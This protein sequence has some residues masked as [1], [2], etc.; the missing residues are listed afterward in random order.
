MEFI[1]KK[2]EQI[3]KMNKEQFLEELE[4]NLSGLP[5]DEIEEIMEDYREHFNI[6]KKKKRREAEIA[7]SLGN[8]KEIALEAKEELKSSRD[9]SIG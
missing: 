8:P 4:K 5:R 3:D 9:V 6:G 2:S 7:K 1:F